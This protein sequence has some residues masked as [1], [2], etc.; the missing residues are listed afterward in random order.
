MDV[1]QF[2][3]KGQYRDVL[4]TVASAANGGQRK[5]YRVLHGK[6]RVEYYIVAL[7]LDHSRL[8]GVKA[9]AVET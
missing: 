7:D 8:V 1:K 5:A 3:P 4:D 9:R 2:D 6:T